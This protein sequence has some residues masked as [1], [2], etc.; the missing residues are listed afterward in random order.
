MVEKKQSAGKHVI[1]E[2]T[3][4][5]VKDSQGIIVIDTRT[6]KYW[7]LSGVEESIWQQIFLQNS[8][9]VITQ[10]ISRIFHKSAQESKEIFRNQLSSWI[11]RGLLKLE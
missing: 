9:E 7:L 3:I 2:E 8:C 6:K 4:W 10:I 11:D 5:W 1:K